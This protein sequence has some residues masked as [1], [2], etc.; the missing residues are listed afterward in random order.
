VMAERWSLLKKLDTQT[1]LRLNST[2][3]QGSSLPAA[4]ARLV[5]W[6]CVVAAE[7]DPSSETR[8]RRSDRFCVFCRHAD[9]RSATVIGG[10]RSHGVQMA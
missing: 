10:R 7:C 1:R 8:S 2:V 4:L 9:R 5:G 3:V 6:V